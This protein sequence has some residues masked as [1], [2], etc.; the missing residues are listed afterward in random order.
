MFRQNEY[1]STVHAHVIQGC[2]LQLINDAFYSVLLCDQREVIKIKRLLHPEDI[3]F[4]EASWM[5]NFTDTCT[6]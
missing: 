1:I 2:I 6:F 3:N 4:I 5:Q